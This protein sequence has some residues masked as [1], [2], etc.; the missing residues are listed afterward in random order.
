MDTLSGNYT[1]VTDARPESKDCDST[2]AIDAHMRNGDLAYDASKNFTPLLRANGGQGSICPKVFYGIDS[3]GKP[4]INV[5]SSYWIGSYYDPTNDRRII[6]ERRTM[7]GELRLTSK[8]GQEKEVVYETKYSEHGIYARDGY[9][10]GWLPHG[11]NHSVCR[12]VET[13][14]A[15]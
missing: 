2:L 8:P 15:Q 10:G 9:G 1:L 6:G 11:S 14:P 3:K 5:K 4:Y 12:Y 13:R 7:S